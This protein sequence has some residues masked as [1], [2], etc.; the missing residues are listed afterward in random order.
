MS[1]SSRFYMESLTSQDFPSPG[2]TYLWSP[3]L[4]RSPFNLITTGVEDK[5]V[6]QVSAQNER[7]SGS[8][9]WEFLHP[10]VCYLILLYSALFK[11]YRKSY[12]SSNTGPLHMLYAQ[13]LF[14][15]NDQQFERLDIYEKQ[16]TLP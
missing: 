5:A 9:A 16:N 15:K 13:S 2:P 10:T 6:Y 8:K 7:S 3:Y 4:W 1:I 14:F 11:S 12:L